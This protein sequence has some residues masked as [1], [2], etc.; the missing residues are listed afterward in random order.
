[1]QTKHSWKFEAKSDST[2]T[3]DGNI[4][5]PATASATLEIEAIASLDEVNEMLRGAVMSSKMLEVW[6]INLADKRSDNK[7]GAQYARG[8]LQSWEVPSEIGKLTEIKTTMNVDQLPVEGEATLT[9]EQ[10]SAIQYA[11]ADT[12]PATEG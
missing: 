5:S 7:Y 4:N 2:E 3:K 12:N 8:Y 11:F 6:D 1:M 9:E 10:Q